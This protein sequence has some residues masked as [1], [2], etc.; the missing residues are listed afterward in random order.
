MKDFWRR[1]QGEEEGG[2]GGRVARVVEE[3][4]TWKTR[5]TVAARVVAVI[6]WANERGVAAVMS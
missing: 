4:R 6:R 5:F 1:D 3:E 2:G